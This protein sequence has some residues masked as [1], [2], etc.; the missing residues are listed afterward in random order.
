[1]NSVVNI[2][3]IVFTEQLIKD[4][5]NPSKDPLNPTKIPNSYIYFVKSGQ[6]SEAIR[7][8]SGKSINILSSKSVAVEV[9]F[10]TF[11]ETSNY[12]NPVILYQIN[13]LTASAISSKSLN[14]KFFSDVKTIVPESFNPLTCQYVEK[15]FWYCSDFLVG[16]GTKE[17][18]L[19]IALYNG[20]ELSILGYFQFNQTLSVS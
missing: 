20:N 17:Y 4:F 19:N 1:M 3:I 18:A 16:Q 13:Q 6:S 12:D 7:G 14:L 5:L 2:T 10:F 9:N 8:F 11:S 15:D